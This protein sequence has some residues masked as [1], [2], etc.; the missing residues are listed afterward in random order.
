VRLVRVGNGRAIGDEGRT[1]LRVVPLSC[2]TFTM[3]SSF[4]VILGLWKIELLNSTS[5]LP[6]NKACSD[7][8]TIHDR[9]SDFSKWRGDQTDNDSG[10]FHLMS[11]CP[12]KSSN[13]ASTT[14]GVAWTNR[15]CSRDAF[16]Q[17]GQYSS[18]TGITTKQENN[19][20][21]WLVVAHEIGHNF[22]R[23]QFPRLSPGV[24]QAAKLTQRC[25]TLTSGGPRV[26]P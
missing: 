2:T 15:V 25:C 22:G 4:N 17:N 20:E 21:T 10:L 9:L 3:R 26:P 12:T 6:F 23:P 8:Y 19:D 13:G 24:G 1:K 5:N 14:V 7:A 18:G 16:A 11:M